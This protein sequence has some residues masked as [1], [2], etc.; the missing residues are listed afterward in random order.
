MEIANAHVTL[1]QK[2]YEDLSRDI[3]TGTYEI[4]YV[5]TEKALVE[6]Y[7]ISKSP[8]REA[9]IE[10]SSENIVKPIP[11]YGYILLG[12]STEEVFQSQETRIILECGSLYMGH[13]LITDEHLKKLHGLLSITESAD[14][15]THWKRN[16]EFHRTLME[17]YGNKKT[18]AFF[19]NIMK[20]FQRNVIQR[21]MQMHSKQNYP[22]KQDG[23]HLQILKHLENKDLEKAMEALRADILELE[24]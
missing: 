9:L 7:R 24:I 12:V 2:V 3:L 6:K 16:V 18:L 11:R 10:L 1:K 22:S 14:A 23:R 8:I 20:V 17:C 15:F 5:F 19:D 21:N 13:K 4:G